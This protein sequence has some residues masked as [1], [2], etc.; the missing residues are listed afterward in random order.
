MTY[1]Y[2]WDKYLKKCMYIT[3][4]YAVTLIAVNG[5]KEKIKKYEII[6]KLPHNILIII[7]QS[8]FK[9][10]HYKQFIKTRANQ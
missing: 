10:I 1:R 5:R 7:T 8:T 3:Y 4:K 6:N 9:K 2:H